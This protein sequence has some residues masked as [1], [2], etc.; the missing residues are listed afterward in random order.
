MK[1]IYST[2]KGRLKRC[3]LGHGA[4]I[5]LS[6]GFFLPL[7]IGQHFEAELTIKWTQVRLSTYIMLLSDKVKT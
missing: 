5:L 2:I 1:Y 4:K 3:Q 6:A 7:F